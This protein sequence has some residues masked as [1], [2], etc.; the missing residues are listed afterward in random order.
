M[1]ED[2]ISRKELS[3]I[4]LELMEGKSLYIKHK[5]LSLHKMLI[6]KE[7]LHIPSSEELNQMTKLR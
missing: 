3:N 7:V 4:V 1:H 6:N 2:E 5:Y